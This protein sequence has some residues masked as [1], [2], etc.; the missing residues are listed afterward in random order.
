MIN[1]IYTSTNIFKREILSYF[2][3][4]VAYVFIAIFLILS[5]L[6]TFYLGNFFELGQAN[7]SSFFEWH[8]WLYLFLIPS[9]TMRLWAEEKK[10]GTIEFITTLPISITSIVIGKF[11]ASWV[12]TIVALTLTFPFWITVNYMGNPDNGVIL[13]S[14]IGSILMAGGYL[15][16]GSCISAMT[17]NQVIAFVVSATIS[18]L[19]TVSGLPIVLDFFSSWSGQTITDVVASLSFLT[20]Y[21]DIT[22]GLIDLRCLLY[23]FTLI[24]FFLYINVL[25]VNNMRDL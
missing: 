16:I 5:G 2:S 6:F 4:P 7:L 22:R 11:F 14:Y 21:Y 13:A 1:F 12:F 9:I 18:F 8:P 10:S 20:N 17:S 15:A 3:T 23:F 19:F 25:I 24:F